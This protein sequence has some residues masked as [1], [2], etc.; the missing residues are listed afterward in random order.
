MKCPL[1]SNFCQNFSFTNLDFIQ[2]YFALKKNF[3]RNIQIPDY[4]S[5]RPDIVIPNQGGFFPV[6]KGNKLRA[7]SSW[8][9]SGTHLVPKNWGDDDEN[10]L[11]KWHTWYLRTICLV[12]LLCWELT[13]EFA[14]LTLFFLGLRSSD[15]SF[16]ILL[17]IYKTFHISWKRS[18]FLI[19]SVVIFCED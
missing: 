17:Q 14:E 9:F 18:C 6:I 10:P 12:A 7:T 2:P 16:R 8:V 19:F 5:F 4:P 3:K 15:W 13:E 1:H 11:S